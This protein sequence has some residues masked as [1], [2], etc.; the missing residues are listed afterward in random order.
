MFISSYLNANESLALRIAIKKMGMGLEVASDMID[1]ATSVGE[2]HLAGAFESH[3]THDWNLDDADWDDTDH[4]IPRDVHILGTTVPIKAIAQSLSVVTGTLVGVGTFGLRQLGVFIDKA[5]D[6]F[7]QGALAGGILYFH[8]MA[9]AA[10]CLALDPTHRRSSEMNRTIGQCVGA[11][12]EVAGRVLRE[13]VRLLRIALREKRRR[14]LTFA[15]D[16]AK[17]GGSNVAGWVSEELGDV[18]EQ[19]R[20]AAR[21]TGAA[22]DGAMKSAADL[23][24]TIRD[25]AAAAVQKAAGFTSGISRNLAAKVGKISQGQKTQDSEGSTSTQ[26]SDDGTEQSHM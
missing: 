20:G 22:V 18:G 4:L 12:S 14:A 8:G 19:V 16:K 1:H 24:A 9:I 17:A 10:D 26:L 6:E 25:H 11:S 21:T 2:E 23:S 7:F 15:M 3:E 5:G 13:S